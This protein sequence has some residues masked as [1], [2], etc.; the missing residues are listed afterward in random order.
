MAKKQN[1]NQTNI[2]LVAIVA[3]I[4]IVVLVIV[5]MNNNAI[6]SSSNLG[7]QA[8]IDVY[9]DVCISVEGIDDDCDGEVDEG[10]PEIHKY[11]IKVKRPK[12]S[13]NDSL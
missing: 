13:L 9:E 2:F 7:G 4:A 6:V 3:I 5:V 11:A 10:L 12:R 1:N 8:Y